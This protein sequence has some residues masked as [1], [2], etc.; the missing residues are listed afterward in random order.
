MEKV[1]LDYVLESGLP[2][3]SQKPEDYFSKDE[4]GDKFFAA[5]LKGFLILQT[6]DNLEQFYQGLYV[7]EKRAKHGEINR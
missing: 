3:Y 1:K 6:E 5:Q 2:V 7:T 4:L